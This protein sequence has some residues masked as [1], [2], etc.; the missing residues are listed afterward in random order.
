MSHPNLVLKI[1]GQENLK[2]KNVCVKE[3]FSHIITPKRKI[4][5]TSH[6]YWLKFICIY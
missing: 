1:K 6:F 2:K 3:F 5:H 4:K